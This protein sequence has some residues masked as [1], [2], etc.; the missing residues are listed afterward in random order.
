MAATV[1]VLAGQM[2]VNVRS[3]LDLGLQKHSHGST[4]R[5]RTEQAARAQAAEHGEK[6]SDASNVDRVISELR[7]MQSMPM[8]RHSGGSSED[9]RHER[10]EAT[11]AA[12]ATTPSAS[13]RAAANGGHDMSRTRADDGHVTVTGQKRNTGSSLHAAHDDGLLQPGNS[14]GLVSSPLAAPII[15]TFDWNGGRLGNQI[16]SLACVTALSGCRQLRACD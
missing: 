8:A 14:V 2:R 4:A 7:K 15:I 16:R 9:K 3:E 11:H 13:L 10:D 12:A 6:E 1:L 5:S